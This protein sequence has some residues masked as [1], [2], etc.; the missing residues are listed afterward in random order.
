MEDAKAP[1]LSSVLLRFCKGK[2]GEAKPKQAPSHTWRFFC[3]AVE[4]LGD[5][6]PKQ[7]RQFVAKKEELEGPIHPHPSLLPTQS[8]SPAKM[9]HRPVFPNSTCSKLKVFPPKERTQED[10]A[11][12]GRECKFHKPQYP[13]LQLKGSFEFLC[14]LFA[15]QPWLFS[16]ALRF[17]K[18][19]KEPTRPPPLNICKYGRRSP[20]QKQQTRIFKLKIYLRQSPDKTSQVVLFRCA[21]FSPSV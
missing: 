17:T 1:F 12:K 7:A 3:Q 15:S 18:I 4:T 2:K 9:S 11:T 8:F 21:P 6:G 20:S 5:R 10:K 13:P 14:L 19:G 16:K